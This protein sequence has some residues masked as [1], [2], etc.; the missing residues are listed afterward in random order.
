[1]RLPWR[2]E[3]V[4]GLL[5]SDVVGFQRQV[6]AQNF[7][8]VARRLAGAEGE[9][10]ELQFEGRT[11]CVGP[12]PISIDVGEFDEIA[13]RPASSER[14]REIRDRLGE[15]RTILL[16]VDRLDYTKGID[17]RLEAYQTLLR[18]GELDARRCVMVQVAVPTREGIED[19]RDERRRV[20]EL[21]GEI[22]GEFASIGYPAVQYLRQSLPLE[23][24]VPMYQ[25]ADVMIVTPL[26]DGMNLVAKEFAAS[27][28]DEQGV[29]VLSEFAGAADELTEAILV[30][31]HDHAALQRAILEAVDMEPKDARERMIAIRDTVA[32]SD[33]RHW[34]ST[35]LSLLGVPPTDE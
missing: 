34:A 2:D 24:L 23:D 33:V 31:P 10:P 3:V 35:F 14:A 19:Y 13:R 21:V 30:N 4:R 12:F 8:A 27:R 15:P 26:R 1:M 9:P 16:G 11:V 32:R 7:A 5:A 29:L 17:I 6:G 20:E 22:N 28:I 25:A 18:D